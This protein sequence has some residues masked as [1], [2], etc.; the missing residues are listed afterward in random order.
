M[1]ASKTN[2]VKC[3]DFTETLTEQELYFH[4][5]CY[6]IFCSGESLIYFSLAKIKAVLNYLKLI[7]KVNIIKPL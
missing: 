7:F 5:I 6:T 2:T 3:F 4:C 1:R